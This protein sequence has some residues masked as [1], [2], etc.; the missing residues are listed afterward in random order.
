MGSGLD[1]SPPTLAE[2]RDAG[3]AKRKTLTPPNGE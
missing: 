3:E 2:G 1:I